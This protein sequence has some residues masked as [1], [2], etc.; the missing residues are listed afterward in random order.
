[1]Y[2]RVLWALQALDEQ[3]FLCKCLNLFQLK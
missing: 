3:R 1:M 2:D